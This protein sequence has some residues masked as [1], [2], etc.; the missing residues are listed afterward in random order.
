MPR[1]LDGFD[2][3]A[4]IEE[5]LRRGPL[6][7]RHPRSLTLQQVADVDGQE[8]IDLIAQS[9]DGTIIVRATRACWH[10]LLTG[11]PQLP[12]ADHAR[13]L[14]LRGIID[15]DEFARRLDEA[16]A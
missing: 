10:Q 2:T 13:D 4:L 8:S 9:A 7:I 15:V 16:A 3:E 6:A 11:G 14:Y 12:T 5:V 1:D